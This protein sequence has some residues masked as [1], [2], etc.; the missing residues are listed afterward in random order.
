MIVQ[1]LSTTDGKYEGLVFDTDKPLVSPDGVTFRS[2]KIQNLGNGY[3]RF[4]NSH[5]VVDVKEVN[6]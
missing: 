1:I 3:Y 4:S 2:A 5:Y 6:E